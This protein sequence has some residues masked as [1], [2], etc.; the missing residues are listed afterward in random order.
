MAQPGEEPTW[1]LCVYVWGQWLCITWREMNRLLKAELPWG[2]EKRGQSQVRELNL[3]YH[4]TW[5]GGC[6]DRYQLT[7]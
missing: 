4:N 3:T 1:S 6:G 2:T 5:R 7:N